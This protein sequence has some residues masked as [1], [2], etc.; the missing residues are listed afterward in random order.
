LHSTYAT[1]ISCLPDIDPEDVIPPI[2]PYMVMRVGRVKLLPYI[3]PGDPKMGDVVREL[4]GKH[5]AILLANHGPA[6]AA[7]DLKS[8]VFISE[9]LE[10]SAKIVLLL[11]DLKPRHLTREQI[12]ELVE[13]FQA[14]R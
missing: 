7:K 14:P 5:A 10:E 6:V 11:R 1:A 12:A 2:T 9:E 13:I 3:R 8:A 4:G